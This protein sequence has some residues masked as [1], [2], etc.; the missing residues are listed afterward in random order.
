VPASRVP[1]GII[2]GLLAAGAA[3]PGCATL[4]TL[5]SPAHAVATRESSST[6]QLHGRLLNLH[7]AKPIAKAIEKP[8][9]VLY[10]SGDGGWFGTAVGMFRTIA[11][12][13]F[14][15]VGLSSRAF[16]KL[17]RPGRAA[18]SPRQVALDYDEV[19]GAAREA[20]E[21]PSD[22][23]AVLTGWSRGASLAVL[24]AAATDRPADAAGVVAIGMTEGEDLTIDGPDDESDD[25]VRAPGS[26]RWSFEPY[27][28]LR[29]DVAVPAAVIQST[30]DGYLPA[31]DARTLFGKDTATRRFYAIQA[32]S[33]GFKGGEPQFVAA[34]GD[35]LH[36][37]RDAPGVSRT[38]TAPQ[39][40]DT[41]TLRGHELTVHTYGVRGAPP[42]VV[43]SGDGG[44]IHLGPH[45]AEMLAARGYF[46]VGFDARAYLTSFTSGRETLRPEDEPGDYRT[47]AAFAA[48]GS[49]R[50]PVLVG[51]SEGAG[52]SLMAATD[53]ATRSAIAGVIGLG[54]PDVNELGWRWRDAM[55]YFTHGTPNEPTFSAVAIAP[56]A[57]PVPLAMI[58]ST[59]DEFVPVPEARR[60]FAA[61]GEPKKLWIVDAA[62]HR[63]SDNLGELD[64][65]LTEALAW[66]AGCARGEL[67]SAA[68]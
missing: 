52:L 48:R 35:A 25:G 62:D 22:T 9:L 28:T 37:V 39:G 11:A 58:Q 1:V 23:P 31:D 63:F 50:K 67:A 5:P 44:W 15:T 54:L 12:E 21:L 59:H 26:R 56:R 24:A 38:G 51:V 18:L 65:R 60:V 8:V 47:L 34:L 45:V 66:I 6:V 42:I 7:L 68:R 14:P 10:A 53:P 13:G 49:G 2:V 33:H 30:G 46:V 29:H 41:V 55:I 57:A 19:L 16:L 3:A 64:Q 20:L 27:K 43:S 4:G 17:E 32:R 40:T 61:A 36:W